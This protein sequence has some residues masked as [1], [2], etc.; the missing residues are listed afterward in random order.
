MPVICSKPRSVIP[1]SSRPRSTSF[2]S[3]LQVFQ[4]LVG[5]LRGFAGW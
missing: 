1:T 3:R 2:G 5:Q 4:P